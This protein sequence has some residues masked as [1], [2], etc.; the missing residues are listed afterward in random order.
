MAGL[1]SSGPDNELSGRCLRVGKG[2]RRLGVRRT[3]V[4]L[5]EDQEAVLQP[6]AEIGC[7]SFACAYERPDGDVV[8]ITQDATDVASLLVGQSR[9]DVA[10]VRSAHRI[11]DRKLWGVIMERLRPLSLRQQRVLHQLRPAMT[12]LGKLYDRSQ[13][14]GSYRV[15]ETVRE[16]LAREHCGPSEADCARIL[17]QVIDAHEWYGRRGI[18]LTDMHAGNWGRRKDGTLALLDVGMAPSSG[19]RA[20]IADLE[21]V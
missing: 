14:D 2:N 4:C 9:R 10:R 8:K 12:E 16:H 11:G 5:T 6:R 1:L 3:S 13:A 20:V 15:P 7:G 18:R 17:S 19:V 21:Q